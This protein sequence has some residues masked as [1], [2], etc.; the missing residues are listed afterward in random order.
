MYVMALLGME[1]F[2]NYGRFDNDG[3]LITDVIKA[4]SKK[5]FMLAP[6]ENFDHVGGALTTVF[7]L[8]LGEDWPGVMYNYIRVYDGNILVSIYFLFV[9][10]LG[11]LMMLSL[12]TAILLQNFEGGD[13]DDEEEEEKKKDEPSELSV[14]DMLD[15]D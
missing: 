11:N 8:I 12:F 2:A 5:E 13:D 4:T 6:R 3:N 9:F 15:E 14:N 10:S 1:L 7:I